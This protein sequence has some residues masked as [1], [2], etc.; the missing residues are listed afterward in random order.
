MYTASCVLPRGRRVFW[1]LVAPVTTEPPIVDFRLDEQVDAIDEKA[2]GDDDERRQQ[3]VAAKITASY[4]A[5][6]LPRS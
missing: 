5:A 3:Y 4:M 2:E 6:L 1:R